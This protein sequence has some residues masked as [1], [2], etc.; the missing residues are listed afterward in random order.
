MRNSDLDREAQTV[1]QDASNINVV[2]SILTAVYV[3][4]FFTFPF[5]THIHL[6]ASLPKNM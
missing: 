3:K 1:E 6:R 2:S 5:E 4:E